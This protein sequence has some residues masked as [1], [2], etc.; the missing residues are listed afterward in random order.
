MANLVYRRRQGVLAGLDSTNTEKC[1]P[2]ASCPTTSSP[3][4]T[5]S[6]STLRSMKMSPKTTCTDVY[7]ALA[8]YIEAE[9][10]S[11]YENAG[12]VFGGLVGQTKFT[13]LDHLRTSMTLIG[14]SRKPM[15]LA[16][17]G[18]VIPFGASESGLM[19]I[20]KVGRTTG[21]EPCSVEFGPLTLRA[22][23]S[24]PAIAVRQGRRA[25]PRFGHVAAGSGGAHPPPCAR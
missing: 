22:S 19:P 18:E 15:S 1:L 6:S 13:E 20:S 10:R 24:L 8:R 14:V 25:I 7:A 17:E 9:C 4:L 5:R 2:R 3:E 23:A 16:F 21:L 12:G 11:A